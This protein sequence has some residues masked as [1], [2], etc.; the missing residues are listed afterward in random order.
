MAPNRYYVTTPQPTTI[1][2]PPSG[3]SGTSMVVPAAA[4]ASWPASFPYTILLNWGAAGFEACS[5]TA[6]SSGTLTIVRGIDGTSAST[7]VAGETVYHGTTA[8]DWAEPQAHLGASSAVHGLTGAV[9]GTT[10]T[11]TLTGKTLTTPTI[12]MPYASKTTTY[13]ITTAD[14]YLTADATGG[15]F[16]ITLP[17]AAVA[18]YLYTIKKIDSSANAVTIGTTSAQTIDGQTTYLLTCQFAYVQVVSDGANWRIVDQSMMLAKIVTGSIANSVTETVIGTFNSIPANDPIAG[19]CYHVSARG[20]ADFTTSPTV[21]IR[22]RLDSI[23]GARQFDSGALTCAGTLTNRAWAVEARFMVTATGVSGSYETF[24][25]Y[26]DGIR[27]SNSQ[28]GSNFTGQVID[29]TSAHTVVVTA[30]WGTA[31]ASNVCRS[32]AGTLER[33]CH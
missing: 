9:V 31:S 17:T 15:A 2:T 19:S 24:G 29:T 21:T 12:V 8:Q 27:S 5:V 23:T 1:T 11:Q 4:A 30:T 28:I 25:W 10:D 14:S 22:V 26:N 3:T 33:V 32:L 16:T 7:H 13:T 6:N 18:G 20:T